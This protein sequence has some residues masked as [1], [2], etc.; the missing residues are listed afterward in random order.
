MD[1]KRQAIIQS[2]NECNKKAREHPICKIYVK[3]WFR[4]NQ[5]LYYLQNKTGFDKRLQ[6][7]RELDPDFVFTPSLVAKK[8][9][10]N[11]AEI[12][13]TPFDVEQCKESK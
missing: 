10:E 8:L 13:L 5:D 2:A 3:R 12:V 9:E 11:V 1:P 7:I 4:W 6:A